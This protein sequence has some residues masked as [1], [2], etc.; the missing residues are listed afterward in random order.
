MLYPTDWNTYELLDFGEGRKLERFADLIV[1]RPEPSATG[2][3]GN[4][5]LWEKTGSVF[6]EEKGQKGNWDSDIDSFIIN[7]RIRDMEIKFRLKQTAFKHLGIFPEQAVNWHFIADHCAR[8]QE[9][10]VKPKVLNLFAYTGAASLIADQ[11][12]AQVTHVD[13]SKSVVQWARDNA[14]LN[15]IS[16]IRWIVEDARKFVERSIKREEKY[17]GIIL[18]PPIFGMVQK[19]KNW[20]LNSDLKPLLENI[21]KVLDPNNHFL[22]LNTYSPQLPLHKLKELL[23]PISGFPKNYEATSLGLKSKSG[24]QLALGNLIRF[25]GSY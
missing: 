7:Y 16:S 2:K 15:H 4:N 22:I 5:K 6:N 24:K 3:K 12:G 14:E 1:D 10:D 13:S 11:F 9:K 23:A 17:H 21:L 20:K 18:D 8:F 25:I 19:G